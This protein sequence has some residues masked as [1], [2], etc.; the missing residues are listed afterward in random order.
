MAEFLKQR[1]VIYHTGLLHWEPGGI[2]DTTCD[3]NI[4]HF[5]FDTQVGKG[6]GWLTV[7]LL[8]IYLIN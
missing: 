4:W 1:V 7:S 6:I 2:F 3:I 5:P 8:N